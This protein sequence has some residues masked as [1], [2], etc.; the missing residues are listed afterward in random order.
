MTFADAP[1]VLNNITQSQCKEGCNDSNLEYSED[2][3]SGDELSEEDTY[4]MLDDD[5][6]ESD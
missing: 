3:S 1:G 5:L 4:S 6:E 2:E